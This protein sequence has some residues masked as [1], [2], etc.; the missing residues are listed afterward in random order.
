MN[1]AH[2]E[3]PESSGARHRLIL[4]GGCLLA[5]G[6]AAVNVAFFLRTGTSVSHLTGDIMR[7]STDVARLDAEVMADAV[8]VGSAGAGFVVGAIA[9]GF[10]IHHPQLDL[11]RPYGRTITLIGGILIASHFLVERADW[12]SIGLAAFSC[13]LQNSLASRYRGLI[14]RT[15]HLTGLLTDFGI[16]VGMRLKGH[17]LPLWKAGVPA[18]IALSFFI[19]GVLAAFLAI[20]WRVPLLP[21]VGAA[22]LVGGVTWSLLKKLGFLPAGDPVGPRSG[23]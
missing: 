20:H 12:L 13:G 6:A 16:A 19:G 1:R 7:L 3:H 2:P 9:A 15:T 22:Y 18:L 17:D 5:L 21:W 23:R 14:L 10:F 11:R 4:A 8:R